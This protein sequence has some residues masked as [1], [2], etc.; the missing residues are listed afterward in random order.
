MIQRRVATIL[1]VAVVA[2]A[3]ASCAP[4]P[5]PA[6]A[7]QQPDAVGAATPEAEG[8]N[9][10]QWAARFPLQAKMDAD[11]R[12]MAPSPTGY[13]GSVPFQRVG[14]VKELAVNF[15][16][17]PFSKDYAEDRGHVYAWED[18]LKTKRVSDKSPGACL[19]CKT[20]SIA[21]IYAKEG[22]DYAKKPLK[23]F[24]S[25]EHPGIDC[26]TCHDKATGKLR[27]IQPGF[28]DA[29]KA[30]GIDFDQATRGQMETYVCAQCH[31]EY[32]FEPGTTKVVF[33]WAKGLG[34]QAAWDYYE[35]KPA[36]FDGDFTHDDSK[37]RLLKAQHP[38]YEEYSA[39]VHG[40]SKVSCATCHMP[41]TEVDGKGMRSHHITTP[42][43]AVEDSCL[44]C[45]KS[46]TKDWIVAQ[47]KSRQDAVYAAQTRAGSAVADAHLAIAAA[48]K[49]APSSPDLARARDL[50]RKAQWFW[51]YTASANSMGFHDPVGTL[52]NLSVSLEAAKDASAVAAAIR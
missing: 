52:S 39:G 21:D 43:A 19:S 17:S 51:D 29:A 32:Y 12:I 34:A 31:S 41:W 36:G 22:W 45:H 35:T 23:E 13:G 10:A 7:P 49:R 26:L 2:F 5:A 15:R 11:N 8:P 42:L 4:K 48:A 44:R 14:L 40:Q 46:K 30:T 27:P 18:L 33:P 47:V 16:G 1:S 37:A 20:S 6:Q 28:L 9:A 24:T 25:T 38:D 3:V 50:V